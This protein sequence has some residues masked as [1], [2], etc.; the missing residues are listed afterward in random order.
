MIQHPEYISIK[1]ICILF[2]SG[3]VPVSCLPDKRTLFFGRQ[4]ECDAILHHLTSGDTRLV[5][6]WGP[7]G[8]GKTSVAIEVAHH[9][10]EKHIPTYFIPVRGMKSKDELVSKLLSIFTDTKQATHISPSHMVIQC[11]REFQNPFVV[12]LDNADDLLESEDVQQR[13]EVLRLTEEILGQCNLIRLLFTTRGSLDYL[14]H[15]GPI[16]LVKVE[17]LEEES[18]ADLVRSM[19]PGIKDDECMQVVKACGQ[20]PLALGLM[21]STMN[22]ENLSVIELLDE[23]KD[24]PLVDVLDNE[25]LPSDSRLKVI[26]N[27]SF[28]RFTDEE[29]KSFVSLAVFPGCFGIEEANCVLG[30]T[31]TRATT[32][33]LRSLQQKSFINCHDSQESFTI[34]SLLQSFIEEKC[35]KDDEIRDAF[36]SAQLRFYN[37]FISSFAVDNETFLT[38]YSV[39]AFT[40]F[41]S[42]RESI[43]LSLV[44][45]A[46][47]EELYRKV[48]DALSKAEIFLYSV[49]SG[50][51]LL[52]DHLFNTAVEEAM[53]RKNGDDEAMLKAAKAFGHLVWFHSGRQKWDES[54]Q[55]GGITDTA[56]VPAKLLCYRSVHQLLCGNFDEGISSLT[57]IVVRLSSSYDEQVLKVLAYH[58]LAVCYTKKQE[59]ETASHYENLCSIE[60]KAMSPWQALRYLFAIITPWKRELEQ[61]S[62]FPT[63]VEQDAMMFVV[64]ARLLPSLYKVFAMDDV[65]GKTTLMTHSLLKQYEILK[66]FFQKGILPF[67][68]LESCCDAL[69][70]LNCDV[71]AAEG[72]QLITDFLE[73]TLGDKKD[74]ARNFHFLGS[75]Y[76]RMKDYK[77]AFDCFKRALDIRE[78]LLKG[79]MDSNHNTNDNMIGEAIG[80]LLCSLETRM[81][82]P[83]EFQETAHGGYSVYDLNDFKPS[84]KALRGILKFKE[85]VP[86]ANL[87]DLARSYDMLGSCQFLMKDYGGA[88]ESYQQAIKTREEIIG[89]HIHTA[90]SLTK[91]GCVFFKVNKNMEADNAL[92]SSLNLRK[93][94]HIDDQLDTA[95]VYYNLGEN[96]F[97]M[98]NG[99]KAVE[100][101]RQALGLRETY[102]GE[103]VLTAISF[104]RVG[105]LYLKMGDYQ[106]AIEPFQ[107]AL[108]LR[109]KLLGNHVDT[110]SSCHNLALTY[111]ETGS[112][113]EALNLSQQALNIRLDLLPGHEE[114]AD[115]FHLQ[116]SIYSMMGD[117]VL[118]SEAFLSSLNLR[119]ALLGEHQDTAMSYHCLGQAQCDSGFY[120]EA[121]DSLLEACRLR[122]ELLGDHSDTATSLELL[123]RTY[124]AL[125]AD[126][127]ASESLVFACEV[128]AKL[129]LEHCAVTA[130]SGDSDNTTDS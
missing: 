112:Y 13:E 52:F 9:L 69:T 36:R 29:K 126:D 84:C 18:S 76:E 26:I 56:D 122:K 64:M 63:I 6:V 30:F 118:A 27:T 121:L 28:E 94:L 104:D 72:F 124:E 73:K 109:E 81:E 66:G 127:L 102:L 8:F 3:T 14:R 128:R 45:G 1:R 79:S 35:L 98:G 17:E 4:Q 114:T 108:Q 58:I 33:I 77:A 50:E 44:N 100:A 59:E 34:H 86:G 91:L 12:I 116:G 92:Q 16:H 38:G 87:L 125:G 61:H 70:T 22:D 85:K 19:L 53:K 82:L 95:C 23:L 67:E 42:Q 65:Q 5:D 10:R 15:R 25:R 49:L 11:L 99:K 2:L 80:S 68:V 106:S 37:Y 32:R 130:T 90:L 21:C 40:A 101:H 71:K 88:V 62:D 129:M 97:T 41:R 113:S 107:N 105:S 57:N 43:V 83:G 115:T 96:F 75:T 51:E 120:N 47:I 117:L 55:A 60:I 93:R 103:H 111:F 123:A 46:R 110:A 39:K 24:A 7:P 20:V 89:D 119:V 54:L 48:V 31:K 78:K 74:T